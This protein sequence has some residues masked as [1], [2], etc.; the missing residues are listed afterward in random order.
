MIRRTASC[1]TFL[2]AAEIQYG[3][4]NVPIK[5]ESTMMLN[6]IE[7]PGSGKISRRAFLFSATLLGGGLYFWIMSFWSKKTDATEAG[8][9]KHTAGPAST[10]T[11]PQ[12][13]D[14]VEF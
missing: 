11:R 5:E 13:V 10:A 8:T 12:E 1:S 14:I 2:A 9:H 4:C 7:T 3:F 6:G